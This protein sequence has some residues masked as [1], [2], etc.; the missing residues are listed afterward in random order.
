ME[1]ILENRLKT[2]WN[3]L[4]LVQF[5]YKTEKTNIIIREVC[6]D[7]W[8]ILINEKTNQ[9]LDKKPDFTY[10][11]KNYYDQWVAAGK[12]AKVMTK[13]GVCEH[14]TPMAVLRER[15]NHCQN[16]KELFELLVSHLT[17]VW[18][19]HEEDHSLKASGYNKNIP[20]CGSDRYE[21]VGIKVISDLIK[22]KNIKNV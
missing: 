1:F 4:Q 19:T 18:I 11:S 13:V 12:S 20:A 21:L 8:N 5:G 17:I 14:K 2:L 9:K 15:M 6:I 22:Y 7:I 10:M 16:T 3:E